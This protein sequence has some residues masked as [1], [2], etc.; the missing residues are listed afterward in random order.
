MKSLPNTNPQGADQEIDRALQTLRAAQPGRA[1][2]GEAH[3]AFDDMNAR[4]LSNI[5]QRDVADTS[6]SRRW[7]WWPKAGLA[8]AALAAACAV[9]LVL[10]THR[11]GN[12]SARQTA[13][14]AGGPSALRHITAA[15]PRTRTDDPSAGSPRS[16]SPAQAARLTPAAGRAATATSALP[17]DP[18]FLP[19]SPAPAAPLTH[20]EE[21]LL[22]TV[23]RSTPTMLAQLENHAPELPRTR[24]RP[25]PDPLFAGFRPEPASSSEA[26]T[27]PASEQTP[28]SLN[29]LPD[30]VT[31]APANIPQSEAPNQTITEFRP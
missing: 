15:Q 3:A 6:P 27:Q 19:S 29:P 13:N 23:R 28:E 26:E 30:P 17:V 4:L 20:Q 25:D 10:P 21:L 16:S 11:T 18:A 8:I 14:T 9:V 7:A 12:Y 31:A 22:S 5:R 24:P 2:D 1:D